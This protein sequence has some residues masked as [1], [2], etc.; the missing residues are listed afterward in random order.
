MSSVLDLNEDI[1]RCICSFLSPK[2]LWCLSQ[3][4]RQLYSRRQL[5][6]STISTLKL[7]LTKAQNLTES[8]SL[9]ELQQLKLLRADSQFASFLLRLPNLSTLELQ[10]GDLKGLRTVRRITKN[11]PAIL[12]CISLI[13]SQIE[14]ET[15]ADQQ[16]IIEALMD[17]N[18]TALELPIGSHLGFSTF[19]EGFSSDRL[20]Q[21]HLNFS[22]NRLRGISRSLSGFNL[23]NS[24]LTEFQ[25]SKLA[26]FLRLEEIRLS[27]AILSCFA[28][29]DGLAEH[30]FASLSRLEFVSCDIFHD[31]F[32]LLSREGC[33]DTLTHL[34]LTDCLSTDLPNL[35]AKFPQLFPHLAVLRIVGGRN[36]EPIK[37]PP[38]NPADL[39]LFTELQSLTLINSEAWGYV[40][41]GVRGLPNSLQHLRYA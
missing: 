33:R 41:G 36:S 26:K 16:E 30:Q 23:L 9:W 11:L 7:H 6:L 20:T 18:P 13:W 35:L 28:V 8:E 29:G 34:S 32:D 21:L 3:V 1:L 40:L 31:C 10:I 15:E 14:S 19:I 25:L 27:H 4:C 2:S 37:T 17:I 38:V 5:L 12:D 24:V 22:Q 39:T